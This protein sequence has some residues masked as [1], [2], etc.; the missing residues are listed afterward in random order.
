MATYH[1]DRFLESITI[2]VS[3][4]GTPIQG[5]YQTDVIRTDD[6]GT[7]TVI[8]TTYETD[9]CLPPEEVAKYLDQ[10]KRDAIDEERRAVA[11]ERSA[12]S[13]AERA[14]A[15]VEQ[16]TE[17]VKALQAKIIQQ[18]EDRA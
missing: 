8:R 10:A 2:H 6:D 14:E 1:D 13:R 7:A 3:T 12:V 15:S 11:A 17:Q 5:R 18:D 9:C 16:L 4:P